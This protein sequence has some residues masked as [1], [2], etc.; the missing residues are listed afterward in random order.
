M[1]ASYISVIK[2]EKIYVKLVQSK[3]NE[4][5]KVINI[6]FLGAIMPIWVVFF[7]LGVSSDKEAFDMIDISDCDDCIVNII[8]STV[9]ESHEECEGFRALGRAR[10]YVDKLVK[11]NEVSS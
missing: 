9:K 11:K 1:E 8:S 7:A 6:S 2:R 5:R 4:S 3:R 10:Q